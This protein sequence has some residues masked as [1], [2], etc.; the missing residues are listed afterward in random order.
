MNGNLNLIDNAKNADGTRRN[1]FMGHEEAYSLLEKEKGKVELVYSFL[2]RH[3]NSKFNVTFENIA[4][5]RG[6][7]YKTVRAACKRLAELGLLEIKNNATDGEKTITTSRGRK[8]CNNTRTFIVYTQP[9]NSLKNF[10]KH[11]VKR[12]LNTEAATTT[13]TANQTPQLIDLP[14]AIPTPQSVSLQSG[15]E[16]PKSEA[17]PQ[18]LHK[19]TNFTARTEMIK[20]KAAKYELKEDVLTKQL[21]KFK[22]LNSRFA[23]E[24]EIEAIAYATKERSTILLEKALKGQWT[25]P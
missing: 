3:A 16:K 11:P 9:I 24:R 25:M 4:A 15:T 10:A 7:S 8:V 21:S 23:E 18:A 13:P 20:K 6:L 22:I 14:T 2:L 1:F 17:Q 19:S 12:K 5:A